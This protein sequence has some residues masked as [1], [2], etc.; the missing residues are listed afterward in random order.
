[1]DLERERRLLKLLDE[2]VA[3]PPPER[4]AFLK[5]E[6][7]TD[8]RLFQ[9]IESFLEGSLST[10]STIAGL[11]VGRYLLGQEN[12]GLEPSGR[13]DNERFPPGTLVSGRYRMVS[14][15]GRG[16]MGEVYRATDIQLG[17]S[18]AIKFLPELL[19]DKRRI[20]ARMHAEVRI[21]RQVSHPNVC[22]VYDIGEVEQ[23][24]YITME[25]IDGEDLAS[26]LRRIGRIPGEKAV[27]I[28]RQLCAG[29]A[30]AHSKG[31]LHR[32][33]KPSNIMINGSG[34]VLIM[35]FG[36][37]GLA[38]H[39][40]KDEI[41]IGTPAYMAPEQLAGKEVS[42]RSDLYALGLVLYEINTGK[43]A[44]E[45][46]RRSPPR[47]VLSLVKDVDPAVDRLISRC[48]EE[49]PIRRPSSAL[50]VAALL[51]GGN[52]LA[53]ALAAGETP[54]PGV[55]AASGESDWLSPRSLMLL[56]TAI[57]ASLVLTV[58]LGAK[59]NVLE[60]IPFDKPPEVLAQK[61]QEVAQ[62]LGFSD[63]PADR[64]YGF[65]RNDAYQQYLVRQHKP[66][67]ARAQLSRGQPALVYFWYRQSPGY[68]EASGAAGVVDEFDPPLDVSGM[69]QLRLDPEGRMLTAF[70]VPPAMA[71]K[72]LADSPPD[73]KA[74]FAAA[75]LNP[76]V[77]TP[78]EPEQT[79]LVAFDARAAWAGSVPGSPD[80]PLR[81]EAAWWRGKPVSFLRWSPRIRQ[82]EVT[83]AQLTRMGIWLMIVVPGVTLAGLMAM[84]NFLQGRG[85]A[86]GASRLAAVILCGAVLEWLC[87]AKHTP[88]PTEFGRATWAISSALFR[89]AAFWVLYMALE[90][91]VRRRWP[92]SL[93]SWSRLMVGGFRDPV[94]AA[95]LLIGVALGIGLAALTFLGQIAEQEVAEYG[96]LFLP[97]DG[98]HTAWFFLSNFWG[99][100]ALALFLLF[101]VL[102]LRILLRRQ[103]MAG[104]V[105]MLIMVLWGSL[106]S[107][108]PLI[109]APFGVAAFGSMLLILVRFGLLPLAM[110][111]FIMGLLGAPLTTHL[112]AWYAGSTIFTLAVV[113]AL[114]AYSFRVALGGRPLFGDGLWES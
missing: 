65:K 110:G 48:L 21:A 76:A 74:L 114:T 49:D 68:L 80:I 37:A 55:I 88:T 82:A 32:D 13:K 56:L 54:S 63:P 60:I 28:A 109:A 81:V 95:Q 46:E 42:I 96:P 19:A 20:H 1:M 18:V 9:E 99:S 30:A 16:G 78:V 70:A 64:A 22:R 113:T 36:V 39:I 8:T 2:A 112:S 45:N 103:W 38:G 57:A 75:G 84:R 47:S 108:H 35:D 90:P 107:S 27:E 33:L 92:Q 67:D 41:G 111:Q 87:L 23:G 98:R 97:L 26:L 104:V 61:A 66:A 51:P 10:K 59:V 79:P 89:A 106:S 29:L 44:L 71:G 11:K 86:R 15:L 105:W 17:Q 83:V 102:L 6:C 85:D 69:I 94:V 7:G 100:L 25:Y 93:V 72:Q 40:E 43:R 62:S 4:L 14:L 91:Y 12:P 77:F 5:R 101:L 50:A 53:E 24:F 58:V 34:Q 3:L 31:V 73:S 52:P